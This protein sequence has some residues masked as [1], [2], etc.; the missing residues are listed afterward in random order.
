MQTELLND[1]TV[2]DLREFNVADA[3][4]LDTLLGVL[5]ASEDKIP[6]RNFYNF[7]KVA[8]EN[9]YRLATDGS[10]YTS[11]TLVALSNVY[12]YLI[13]ESDWLIRL[14]KN[15]ADKERSRVEDVCRKL[16]ACADAAE[17][18]RDNK[19]DMYINRF[20]TKVQKTGYIHRKEKT[21]QVV[22][23]I[24]RMDSQYFAYIPVLVDIVLMRQREEWLTSEL[25]GQLVTLLQEYISFKSD[26]L[27]NLVSPDTKHDQ[28]Q[29]SQL[30]KALALQLLLYKDS[31]DINFT[32]NRALLYRF[33]SYVP[34]ANSEDLLK[35][36]YNCLVGLTSGYQL[37]YNW[38]QLS[39]VGVIAS[40]LAV[41]RE[42]LRTIHKAFS[43]N[44]QLVDI[45]DKA[46]LIT[47]EGLDH[48]NLK[49]AVPST[50]PMWHGLQ[51]EIDGSPSTKVTQTTADLKQFNL[52]W[53]EIEQHLFRQRAKA[54]ATIIK[55]KKPSKGENVFIIIDGI[56]NQSDCSFHATI[57]DELFEGDG[58]I[59][60]K[61]DIV[62]YDPRSLNAS[63]F[64]DN[65][66]RDAETNKPY[67][68][69]A[70][71]VGSV[72]ALLHFSMAKLIEEDWNDSDITSYGTE[73]NAVVTYKLDSTGQCI[74]V[75]EAGP[76]IQ[77]VDTESIVNIGDH[78]LLQVTGTVNAK[79]H[80][81]QLKGEYLS[82]ATTEVTQHQAIVR[83]LQDYSR[84]ET[85]DE[86][87]EQVHI[88]EKP[89]VEQIKPAVI[90]EMIHLI[91]RQAYLSKDL[92][93]RFLLLCV[94]GTLS[95]IIGN[96]YQ[97]EYY[98]HCCEQQITLQDFGKNN[99]INLEKLRKLDEIPEEMV[100]MFPVL[101]LRRQELHALNALGKP[102]DK[103]KL[104]TM[105]ELTD[106]AELKRLCNLVLAY[107][108]LSEFKM[109]GEKKAI[110]DN[111]SSLMNIK[112]DI[113]EALYIGDE[114]ETMEFKSSIVFVA[115]AERKVIADPQTQMQI[116]LK[117]INAFLNTKGGKLY[118]GVNNL[119]YAVGLSD[120]IEWFQKNPGKVGNVTD[121]DTYQ[122]FLTN[123]IYKTWPDINTLIQ[124]SKP[125][126]NGRDVVLVKVEPSFEPLTL[127]GNY[128]YRVGT[129]TRI[130]TK[131][132]EKEFLKRR[133]AQYESLKQ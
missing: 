53:K 104:L 30:V 99:V 49:K 98:R 51:V 114:S 132:G 100:A 28:E 71:V 66:F 44:E 57:K 33:A 70:T 123:A 1:I 62:G 9:Q 83:L 103:E 13:E 24:L 77:F 73:L 97:L 106:N 6:G 59:H 64:L 55:K 65:G 90:E 22:L 15:E 84:G 21:C 29:V 130:V 78:V 121:M 126:C 88:E 27:K 105:L 34:T 5:D 118:I 17:L 94:A 36:A 89:Q 113:Q 58:I 129:E 125:D 69:E 50:I 108:F 61:D 72:G 2:S 11:R 110:I 115:N 82:A 18:L 68:F 41:R 3:N 52:W 116:I 122:Q 92:I 46:I 101:H 40:I 60:I 95:R 80:G 109:E 26:T 96:E 38:S 124:V 7:L 112:L 111:I 25:R 86:V 20:L 87:E 133:P 56:I 107:N 91:D 42:P 19:A 117:E 63:Y 4:V 23:D 119:G 12:L 74:A 81:L 8:E 32:F 47:P 45:T 93:E 128:Y 43:N 75:S 79:K 131:E 85:Y 39:S 76:T 120:D 35:N 127:D 14:P 48:S 16:R 102:D 31:D 37:E 54:A 10:S 67:L